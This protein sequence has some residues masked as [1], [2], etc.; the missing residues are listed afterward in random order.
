MTGGHTPLAVAG[1]ADRHRWAL[2]GPH[3]V[4]PGVHRLP[5]SLPQDGLRA[6]NVYVIDLPDGIALIDAG[7]ATPEAMGELRRG[8][9]E[10]GRSLSDIRTVLATHIHR[11]HYTQAITLR[12]EV[13]CRVYLGLGERPGL[14]TL[15][16]I[17]TDVPVSSLVTLRAAGESLLADS[18]LAEMQADDRYE[19]SIWEDPDEWLQPGKF[20]LGDR[21]LQVVHTPGHT[22][23]HLM[24]VD[25]AAGLMFTGDHVLPHITPSI[26]FELADGG[27]P[28]GDYLDSLQAVLDL[29]DA[30][31]LP[32]HGDPV[33]QVHARV[34]ELLRH[35]DDRLAE[36][37]AVV[38]GRGPSAGG[39]VARRLRWTNS[40]RPFEDLR[41]FDRMLAVCE[42][43]AHLDVLA[44]RGELATESA[45][46]ITRYRR[47]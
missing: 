27:L 9:A 12:R 28:L 25:H 21:R 35:H 13:G 31:M 30:R 41:D 47:P 45:G 2:P 19:A 17:A 15:R 42:T 32:A 26:G 16:R 24:F 8:L 38:V 29:D 11:D 18:I 5:L 33:P 39:E 36:A 46:E 34:R 40:R 22:R 1:H 23:G 10:L 20:Q 6:V 7:W 37:L 43:V 14:T 44:Q 3:P 4:A